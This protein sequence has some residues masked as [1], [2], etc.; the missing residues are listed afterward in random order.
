M[1]IRW[2][3]LARLTY[4]KSSDVGSEVS[5][6]RCT[7]I[8]CRETLY[9]PLICHCQKA[10]VMEPRS[11]L[12]PSRKRFRNSWMSSDATERFETWIELFAEM[13]SAVMSAS[14]RKPTTDA[15]SVSTALIYNWVN[16]GDTKNFP[17]RGCVGCYRRPSGSVP[18]N[19]S[20]ATRQIFSS[21]GSFFLDPF[22]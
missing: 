15:G 2:Q 13:A 5:M 10:N 3:C 6:R 20:T 18:R 8:F 19:A 7:M 22:A 16:L 11:R 4:V 12:F 9:S 14:G 17:A 21:H 1:A